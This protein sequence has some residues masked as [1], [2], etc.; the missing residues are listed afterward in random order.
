MILGLFLQQWQSM[1]TQ[2]FHLKLA[3][4]LSNRS[5][6]VMVDGYTY[7]NK[8]TY[9]TSVCLFY[10]SLQN[11]AVPHDRYSPLSIQVE[12]CY[13]PC[14]R[15]CG[16]AGSQEQRQCFF[17]GLSCSTL[18]VF[19]CFSLSLLSVYRLVVWGWGLWTQRVYITLSLSLALPTILIMIIITCCV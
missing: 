7:R 10:S 17:I 12:R 6:H 9:T 5:Q 1:S 19:Y 2:I 3:Q 14:I 15:W 11:L 13:W 16:P 18:I 4:F 8:Y